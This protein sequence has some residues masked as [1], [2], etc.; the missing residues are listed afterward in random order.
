MGQHFQERSEAGRGSWV[1]RIACGPMGNAAA[2][3]ESTQNQKG[4]G[5]MPQRFLKPGLTTS[6]K[7]NKCSW[8]AQSF[9]VRILTLVDDFGRYEGD[10]QLLRSLA[11]PLNEDIRTP[12]VQ[13]LCDELQ[14]NQL[15]IFYKVDGKDYVQLTNWTERA[16]SD[17]SRYPCPPNCQPQRSAA[18]RSVPRPPK[19]S[20]S[21]S[22]SSSPSPKLSLE[23]AVAG[24]LSQNGEHWKGQLRRILQCDPDYGEAKNQRQWE[25]FFERE[26]DSFAKVLV[27]KYESNK[28]EIERIGA[29][30][31]KVAMEKGRWPK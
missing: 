26:T 4:R 24:E 20:P 18:F 6:R 13:K 16:R 15:A 17:A 12:Q 21:A 30:L 27:K 2:K 19:S 29:Y 1:R 8:Q 9:Y 11:F 31:S 7:W 23:D 14:A 10:A 28:A 3:T 5:R 25:R 22:L